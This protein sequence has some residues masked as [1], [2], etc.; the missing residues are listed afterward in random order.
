MNNLPSEYKCEQKLTKEAIMKGLE[1]SKHKK[2]IREC[3]GKVTLVGNIQG[4]SILSVFDEDFNVQAI[5]IIEIVVKDK[6]CIGELSKVLQRTIKNFVILKFIFED[7]QVIS[8]ALKRLNKNNINDIVIDTLITT[9]EI[10]INDLVYNRYIDYK[11]ISNKSNK[12]LFYREV[13]LKTFIIS[14][15]DAY[16]DF[17]KLLES[18]LWYKNES[19]VVLYQQFSELILLNKKRKQVKEQREMVELNNKIKKTIKELSDISNKI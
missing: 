14:N 16:N 1:D 3:V 9:D 17:E 10:G 7:K 15:R 2:L 5:S 18:S 8:L 13:M 6:K 11:N 4:E 12:I 19:V